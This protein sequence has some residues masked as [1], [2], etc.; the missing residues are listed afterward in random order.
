MIPLFIILSLV[1]ASLALL[2]SQESLARSNDIIAKIK[3]MDELV[4]D[5]EKRISQIQSTD[6]LELNEMRLNLYEEVIKS[7]TEYDGNRV[8]KSASAGD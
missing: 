3:E 7:K 4:E 1:I 6:L 2:R 8:R 5:N